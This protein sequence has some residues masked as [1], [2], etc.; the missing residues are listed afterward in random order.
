VGFLSG[1]GPW[2]LFY[3]QASGVPDGIHTPIQQQ[4]A[5]QMTHSASN[6]PVL[7][8]EQERGDFNGFLGFEV[9]IG[10]AMLRMKTALPR[11]SAPGPRRGVYLPFPV[12][13]DLS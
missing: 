13:W 3:L 10:N 9:H 4:T 11:A 1:I 5:S 7:R 12:T 2:L 6:P 8:T